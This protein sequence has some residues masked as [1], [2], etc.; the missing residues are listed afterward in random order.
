MASSANR[1]RSWATPPLSRIRAADHILVL[2][3]GQVV[4]RGSH[5]QLLR[6]C[7]FY[8]RIFAP[9]LEEPAPAGPRT[10]GAKEESH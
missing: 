5:E 8:R 2:D 10:V 7:S 4:G 3:A 9:Y 1:P 6:D